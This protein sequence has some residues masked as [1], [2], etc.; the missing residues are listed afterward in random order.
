MDFGSQLAGAASAPR[1]VT[2]RNTGT[3]PLTFAATPFAMTG[4]NGADFAQTNDCGATL[5]VDATCSVAVTFTPGASGARSAA[6]A[7]AD[8][9]A[10]SPQS[11]ALS[12]SG[13]PPAPAI[14]V[15]PAPSPSAHGWSARRAR[16]R[17]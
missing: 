16:P 9:A 12:G 3:G 15:S 6:L 1:T 7:I 17:P 10:D 11:V 4:A 13:V 5:A 14:T 8:D 2:L